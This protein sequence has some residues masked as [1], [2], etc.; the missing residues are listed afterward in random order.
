MKKHL[1]L[2]L[3]VSS[4]SVYAM[5][6]HEEE[7]ILP[8]DTNDAEVVSFEHISFASSN[9]NQQSQTNTNASQENQTWE[10]RLSDAQ[11]T[12]IKNNVIAT[13]LTN[14]KLLQK[15]A[16]FDSMSAIEKKQLDELLIKYNGTST[17]KII[18]SLKQGSFDAIESIPQV[19][20][21]VATQLIA[22]EIT[23]WGIERVKELFDPELRENKE[24]IEIITKLKQ[25]S[26]K[27]QLLQEIVGQNI[28]LNSDM[29]KK[30]PDDQTV[31]DI[32]SADNAALQEK[33]I[34][35]FK[36]RAE[37][38]KYYTNKLVEIACAEKKTGIVTL[39]TPTKIA[40]GGT[41]AAI[42]A[43]GVYMLRK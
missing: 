19:T 30:N 15:E 9:E 27:F 33:M 17:Q 10:E 28:K 16:M 25:E 12:S 29:L 14:K 34:K 31:K 21:Q 22:K 42:V 20:V 7:P 39:S 13:E 11:A 26:E 43:T 2:A 3:C 38:I 37:R 5:N 4:L 8:E 36:R 40:L 1:L 35:L 41:A 23:E 18:N 6:P 24:F 32:I